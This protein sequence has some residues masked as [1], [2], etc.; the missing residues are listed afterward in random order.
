MHAAQGINYP[1]TGEVVNRKLASWPGM[2]NVETCFLLGYATQYI[3]AQKTSR[4][5]VELQ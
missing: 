5:I 1:T 3:L 4:E 2:H